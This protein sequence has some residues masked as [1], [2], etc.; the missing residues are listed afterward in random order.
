MS[1]ILAQT[2]RLAKDLQS[3]SAVTIP[4]DVRGAMGYKPRVIQ[5]ELDGFDK[6]FNVRVLHRRFGKTVREV[7][8]LI[9]RATLCPYP[10]GRYGYLAPT[11]G[12]AEDI[13]WLYLSD[14]HGK[15]MR[16]CGRDPEPLQNKGDLSVLVPTRAGQWA[17]VRLYGVD[18]PKQRIR[19]LY[20]DG[21]VFDEFAW[22]PWSVWA[23]QVRPMLSDDVRAGKDFAGNRNQ[24]ADFIFTPFGRNHAHRMFTRA[25]LWSKG[26]PVREQDPVTD[27]EVEVFSDEWDARLYKA[28]Q[29]K[30]IDPRELA[31]ARVDMGAAKYEQEY[32]CSFD[33]AV[34]GAI[35]AHEIEQL[36]AAGR[37]G[38]FPINPL[39]PVHTAWDLGFD[40][41]TAI[42][43]YQ[44]V[45]G[46]IRLIDYLEVINAGLPRIVELLAEKGYRYGIHLLPWD[47]VVGELGTGKTRASV[48]KELG[49]RITVVPKPKY[50]TDRIAATQAMLP[51]CRFHEGN[52]ADGIDRVCLYRREYIEINGVYREKPIHDWSSHA[53]DA[54]G[55][56]AMGRRK[57]RLEGERNPH[58]AKIAEL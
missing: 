41:A 15:L 24:W 27:R 36:R 20:L 13:A 8:K 30:I 1:G 52:T 19:G 12:A 37:I 26:L 49:V 10:N 53:A 22:I 2:K 35:Y 23:Q 57:M 6:R 48:L 25:E 21:V 4:D 9:E 47:V 5:A 32:E 50:V 40:D 3:K 11:Y 31:A 42:W 39:L 54:L 55:T 16:A 58:D 14:M 28:S 17:R 38:I 56:L 18:S 43:F 7:A 44:E 29:T 45:A 46:E 51:L 33:A 34:E